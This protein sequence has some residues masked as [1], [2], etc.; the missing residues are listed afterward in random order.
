MSK[1]PASSRA[2]KGTT[3]PARRQRA[4]AAT[5]V[6]PARKRSRQPVRGTREPARA[7][8]KGRVVTTTHKGPSVAAL[9]RRVR[10]LE[11]QLRAREHLQAE[12]ER[13]REYH[14]QLQEQVKAKDSALAFKEKELSDLRRQLE[15]LTSSLEQ[16]GASA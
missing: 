7:R 1:K 15:V 2:R 5:S 13:W 16:K 8:A 10:S 12:L 14:R 4:R 3:K 11:E 9:Q 6:A